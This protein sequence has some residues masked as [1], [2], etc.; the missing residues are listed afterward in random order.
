VL[1]GECLRQNDAMAA[2]A[3]GLGFSVTSAANGG[4]MSLSLDLQPVTCPAQPACSAE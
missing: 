4:A 2:L 1:V 3:R